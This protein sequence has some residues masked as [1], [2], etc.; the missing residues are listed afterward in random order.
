MEMSIRESGRMTN[1]TVKVHSS[2]TK[3]NI[4]SMEFGKG[5]ASPKEY[6][7]QTIMR[8]SG[9]TVDADRANTSVKTGQLMLEA[10]ITI[11]EM[12]SAYILFLMVMFI[13]ENSETV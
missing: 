5:D 3:A 13:K 1:F 10:G 12:D 11:K 6:G 9:K 2:T 4:W 7:R 8:A